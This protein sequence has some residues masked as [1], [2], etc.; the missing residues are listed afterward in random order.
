LATAIVAATGHARAGHVDWRTAAFFAPATA[1]GGFAGGR[2]AGWFAGDVLV[3]VFAVLMFASAAAMLRPFGPV[4]ASGVRRASAVSIAALGV[5]IGTLTGL[6]GAGG[7][8]LFVPALVFFAA[9]PMQRAVGTSL[10]LIG[11]NALAAIAGHLQHVELR[12]G[13]AAPLATAAAIGALV[14]TRLAG[15]LPEATLRR[16]FGVFVLGVAIWMVVRSPIV[17][18]LF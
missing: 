1:L 16:V 2:A 14:G 10:L 7:G 6:V 15:R 5:V 11:A 13:L 17:Q 3:L 18:R 12:F 8:F 9:L 4:A